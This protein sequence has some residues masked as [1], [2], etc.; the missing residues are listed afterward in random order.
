MTR[1]TEDSFTQV[2]CSSHPI[3]VLKEK[4]SLS[5]GVI[6]MVFTCIQCWIFG[7]LLSTA[8]HSC[9]DQSLVVSCRQAI[10]QKN[11]NLRAYFLQKYE[12][13][14]GHCFAKHLNIKA[15]CF[16]R[17]FVIWP[18]P[19]PT[20]TTSLGSPARVMLENLYITLSLFPGSW[21]FCTFTFYH[22]CKPGRCCKIDWRSDCGG[23]GL[24]LE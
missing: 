19:Q 18:E 3:L 12:N 20:S 1:S 21:I 9:P 16:A 7:K 22:F 8:T 5:N 14:R 10:S 6:F 17:S 23:Q 13:I 24:E 15:H 11:Q 2:K 4:E